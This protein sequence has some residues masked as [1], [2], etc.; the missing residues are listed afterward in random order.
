MCVCMSNYFLSMQ[1]EES[2]EIENVR[3]QVEHNY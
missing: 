2:L 3:K 1:Q